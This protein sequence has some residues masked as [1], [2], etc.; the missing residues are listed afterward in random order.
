M[1]ISKERKMIKMK[2]RTRNFKR[3]TGNI[4]SII[5]V[6]IMVAVFA[7]VFKHY[8]RYDTVAKYHLMLDLEKGDSEALEYYKDNYISDDIYLFDGDISFNLF[9]EK[10]SIKAEEKDR[11]KQD[12][13]NSGLSLNEYVREYKKA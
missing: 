4:I 3:T 6:I 8:E 7:D 12:Y 11:V 1:N 5:I 13:K 10:Y 2:K 9:A